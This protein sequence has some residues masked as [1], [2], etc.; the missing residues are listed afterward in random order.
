MSHQTPLPRPVAAEPQFVSAMP[1]MSKIVTSSGTH[2]IAHQPDLQS[3]LLVCCR[4]LCIPPLQHSKT[5]V[6]R[7]NLLA[8][9]CQKRSCLLHGLSL[10]YSRGR[11]C[12]IGHGRATWALDHQHDCTAQRP[13]DPHTRHSMMTGQHLKRTSMA[14]KLADFW[15]FQRPS[16]CRLRCLTR[17]YSAWAACAGRTGHRKVLTRSTVACRTDAS[18]AARLAQ[19]CAGALMWQFC[20]QGL[21]LTEGRRKAGTRIALTAL[22]RALA[23]KKVNGHG[24]DCEQHC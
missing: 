11:V 1:E 3:P 21:C 13:G 10:P 24:V 16:S 2:Q 23:T 19:L 17:S 22:C 6:S 7:T 14:A 20:G 5:T 8:E 18:H 4:H 15:T 12:T 9:D